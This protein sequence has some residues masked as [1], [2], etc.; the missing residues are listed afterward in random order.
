MANISWIN[1]SGGTWTLGSNWSGGNVPGPS[2]NV[3]IAVAPGDGLSGYTIAL[4]TDTVV[5]SLALDQAAATL[6]VG[7]SLDTHVKLEAGTLALDYGTLSGVVADSGGV[8]QLGISDNYSAPDGSLQ[9]VTWQGDLQPILA[10]EN[11]PGS[12][13]VIGSLKLTGADGNGPGTL[14]LNQS[15]FG[16]NFVDTQTLN[17]A[18]VYLGAPDYGNGTF[19]SNTTDGSA[20]AEL[21]L[22][23]HLLL[24]IVGQ[25][26]IFE[27]GYGEISNEGTISTVGTASASISDEGESGTFANAGTMVINADGYISLEM[28]TVDNSGSIDVAAGGTLDLPFYDG[29][30]SFQNSGTLLSNGIVRLDGTLTTAQVQA[31]D[32]TWGAAGTLAVSSYST[33]VNTG[34]LIVLGSGG[35]APALALSGTVQGGTITENGGA[36]V[37][38]FGTL[39]GVALNGNLSIAGSDTSLTVTNGLQ[40]QPNATLSVTGDG[41]GLYFNSSQSLDQVSIEL[42]SSGGATL[43]ANYGVTLTLGSSVVVDVTGGYANLGGYDEGTLINDGSVDVSGQALLSLGTESADFDNQGVVSVSAGGTLYLDS[44]FSD[45]GSVSLQSSTLLLGGVNASVLSSI[46]LTNSSVAIVGYLNATGTTLDV[47]T[48]SPLGNVTIGLSNPNDGTEG[49]GISGGTVHDS[50]G[51]LQIV[52]TVSLSDV[53][54]Q[55]VLTI[56]APYATV[57][58]SDLTLENEAGTGPG[59]LSLSGA[60]SVLV[61]DTGTILGSGTIDIGSSIIKQGGVT[62]DVPRIES[63]QGL[64]SPPSLGA[65]IVVDQTA[66]YAGLGAGYIDTS[67]SSSA[68]IDAAFKGGKMVLDGGFFTNAGTVT[69]GAG[70]TV[71]SAAGVLINTGSVTV[72][73]GGTLT[74]NFLKY[75]QQLP[76][77]GTSFQNEGQIVLGGGTIFEQGGNGVPPVPVANAAGGSINGAG[78]FGAE[79]VNDGTVTAAGGE[80]TLSKAITGAGVLAVSAAATLSLLSSVSSGQVAQFGGADGVLGLSGR[81]FL[82]EIG[83]FAAGDTIDLLK[84]AAKSAKFVGDSI[85]VTLSHGGTIA[86]ATTQ[87]LTGSL[88]VTGDGHGGSLIGFADTSLSPAVVPDIQPQWMEPQWQSVIWD[89]IVHHGGF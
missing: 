72:A 52:G 83:G 26:D 75:Y 53:T 14:T 22:G 54:Y 63:E 32:I 78:I 49:A 69:V 60:Q 1:T 19:L 66:K 6:E 43:G 65:N 87:E 39:S 23:T 29:M 62:L 64:G 67:F 88:T 71:T 89:A 20:A 50:G 34:S 37:A 80:L 4:N 36:L 84:L 13:S 8:L 2:D 21:T 28:T 27:E 79:L 86:L 76:Y 42:G 47:G 17:N 59:T 9:N 33:L 46:S 58:V 25:A 38:E 55:G 11:Y 15:D 44:G 70:E 81:A 31:L 30:T 3:T 16:V 40:L 77:E 82:G 10:A 45:T 5:K 74:L 24:D 85:V 41:S 12:L 56:A 7:A 35:I 18:T 73:S 48:G 57:G 68:T 61:M 51:G